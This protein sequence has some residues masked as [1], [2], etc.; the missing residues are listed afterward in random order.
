MSFNLVCKF[1]V[2]LFPDSKQLF[3]GRDVTVRAPHAIQGCFP[4]W[5]WDSSPK[6]AELLTAVPQL[7][8]EGMF[9]K[10]LR[11][12]GFKQGQNTKHHQELKETHCESQ[13][14]AVTHPEH[15]G[16]AIQPEH[17]LI[18]WSNTGSL[19]MLQTSDLYFWTLFQTLFYQAPLPQPPFFSML[20]TQNSFPVLPLPINNCSKLL[21]MDLKAPAP[22][23]FY[24]PFLWLYFNFIFNFII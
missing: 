3:L 23:L 20:L 10:S 1:F 18:S 22:Y 17:S 7:F 8:Q 2:C 11:L 14:P 21:H 15:P 6:W 4:T 24:L 13:I 19:L 12:S 16:A 9:K 5:C